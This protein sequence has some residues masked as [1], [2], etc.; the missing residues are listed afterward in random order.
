M[1]RQSNIGVLG[2]TRSSIFRSLPLTST[3]RRSSCELCWFKN[4]YDREPSHFSA[5]G[6]VD[7]GVIFHANL[8]L[9]WSMEASTVRG[10]WGGIK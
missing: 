1:K 8:D 3:S 4:D 6:K 7:L 9:F 10:I 5:S 2:R